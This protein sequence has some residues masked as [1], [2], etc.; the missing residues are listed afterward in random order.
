MRINCLPAVFLIFLSFQSFS[1]V[2]SFKD[3]RWF[4]AK[5][6]GN[7]LYSKSISQSSEALVSTDSIV[8]SLG[9]TVLRYKIKKINE[10]P[11]RFTTIYTVDFNGQ[12]KSITIARL[13]EDNIGG[14]DRSA[15]LIYLDNFQD[16]IMIVPITNIPLGYV[17]P[18]EE[19]IEDALEKIVSYY[20]FM[21]MDFKRNV[22]INKDGKATNDYSTEL[23]DCQ[24]DLAIE[25]AADKTGTWSQGAKAKDCKKYEQS[26][27]WKLQ[28]V[29]VRGHRRLVLYIIA[30]LDSKEFIVTDLTNGRMVIAGDFNFGTGDTTEDASLELSKKKRKKKA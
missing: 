9:N 1:Q 5:K 30:G 17:F 15:A 13:N 22:D 26:F 28:Y 2:T 10:V 20:E 14:P 24:R 18:G 3:N 23:N 12:E 4:D 19:K 7:R 21:T 16:W 6:P 27:K 8:V 25:L 29:P 11:K